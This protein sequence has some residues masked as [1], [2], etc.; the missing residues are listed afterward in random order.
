M[1]ERKQRRPRDPEATREVI[2]E[3]ALKHLAEYGPDGLSL[4]ERR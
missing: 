2:L 3:A 1:A 4:S